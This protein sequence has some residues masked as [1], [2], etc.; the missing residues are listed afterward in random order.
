MPLL[1][2]EQERDV[3]QK[4]QKF[5]KKKLKLR[6]L[7]RAIALMISPENFSRTLSGSAP[8]TSESIMSSK[9]PESSVMSSETSEESFEEENI[10][11][12]VGSLPLVC[13]VCDLVSSNYTSI[14]RKSSYL[15]TVCDGAE[16]GVKT[17]T[18]V[19]VNRAQPLLTS[20]E[21][22]LVTANKYACRGLDTME[23]K[24]PILQQTA[25][26]VVSDTKEL[27]SSKVTD[28][29]NAVT[30]RV[31]GMVGLTKDAVQGSVKTTA[32]MVT[33]SMSLVMGTRMG[34]MAKNSVEAMLGKSYAFVDH[35]LLV[36]E[37]MV[38][39]KTC[40][41]GKVEEPR[42]QMQTQIV[43]DSYLA[44]LLS[45]LSKFHRYASKQSRHHL[46]R[47]IR[48]FQRV[49][50]KCYLEWRAGLLALHYTITLPL[51][52]IH[53]IVL[54]TIEELS[55]KFHEHVPQ[56]SYV[57]AEFQVALS[58][59]DCL[60]DLCQRVFTR[61]WGKMLEEENLNTLLNY[62]AQTLPFCFFVNYCKCRTNPGNT[63]RALKAMQ[64]VQA[65]RDSLLGLQESGSSNLTLIT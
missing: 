27:M 62:I 3:S 34:Q 1:A 13:S 25:D 8:V 24:L 45:L 15:Q 60:Q 9:K 37:D 50:K 32:S 39:L 29:K 49:L 28:A 20:F 53:L 48:C 22:Q 31:S 57:A 2:R 44:C 33:S 12:R 23:E 35:Y 63:L 58:T 42:Q 4:L 59:L 43:C 10:L 7:R 64:K 51:R 61:V 17:L 38:E 18:G 19:A 40:C 56:A 36:D 54:F 52:T 6:K 21:P 26:Q 5:W 55:S 30:R 11:K 65:S 16:K 41:E 47:A 14:K 46:R